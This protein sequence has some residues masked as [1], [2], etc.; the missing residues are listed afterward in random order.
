MA[1]PWGRDL[2]WTTKNKSFVMAEN[3]WSSTKCIDKAP[4]QDESEFCLKYEF[5]T[6]K[7]ISI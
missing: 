5:H 3:S 4:D 2:T 7:N 6:Y 1:D